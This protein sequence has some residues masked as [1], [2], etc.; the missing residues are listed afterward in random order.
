MPGGT[1]IFVRNRE[2]KVFGP[3]EP[4]TVEL[5]IEGG[6][7]QGLL[8]VSTDGE[9]YALPFRFPEV[10]DFFPRHLWG[11]DSRH[12]V[13]LDSEGLS[14]AQG[15][16]T[17]APPAPSGTS[18]PASASAAAGL[19]AP[20]VAPDGAPA[21]PLVIEPILEPAAKAPTGNFP[22]PPV[23]TAAPVE[24]SAP[25]AKTPTGNFP[26]PPVLTAAPVEPS[27]SP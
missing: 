21:P 20:P 14:A 10:R 1:Q 23:L 18:P 5:L 3:I 12:D 11:D 2:G 4:S 13:Q 22:R 8:Q 9:S 19:G 17:V 26:K 15:G 24:P 6:I 25:A 7:L 27:A 16:D